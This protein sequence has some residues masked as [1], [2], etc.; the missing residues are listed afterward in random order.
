MDR[1]KRTQIQVRTILR[2][3]ANIFSNIETPQELVERFRGL[4]STSKEYWRHVRRHAIPDSVIEQ[5]GLHSWE[6]VRAHSTKLRPYQ[7]NYALQFL[8]TI[9]YVS[10]VAHVILPNDPR[11]RI[12]F[13]SFKKKLAVVIEPSGKV[14]SVYEVDKIKNWGEWKVQELNRGAKI[15][16]VPVNDELRKIS[17]DIQDDL[18]RLIRRLSSK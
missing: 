12:I 8:D 13:F 14:A 18:R 6:K 9:A 17:E 7:V 15:T 4:F 5:L 10:N 16:E 1:V 2:D 11:G 3:Y